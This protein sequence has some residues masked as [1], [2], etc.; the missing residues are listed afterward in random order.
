[1]ILILKEM[2]RF[3]MLYFIIFVLMVLI[4]VI[5]KLDID[6][7]NIYIGKLILKVL[8]IFLMFVL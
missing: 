4:L 6:I 5:F 8:E 2:K 7:D 1:M 3:L